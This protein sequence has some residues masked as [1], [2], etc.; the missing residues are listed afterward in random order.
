MAPKSQLVAQEVC[1]FEGT[2][3][4]LAMGLVGGEVRGNF[5]ALFSA[6]PRDN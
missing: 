4:I 5:L 6:R 2:I 3:C 1:L